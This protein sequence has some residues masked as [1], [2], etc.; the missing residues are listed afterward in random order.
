[1]EGAEDGAALLAQRVEAL[2]EREAAE[3]VDQAAATAANISEVTK[4]SAAPVA[5]WVT[6]VTT[7]P[8]RLVGT[9]A[10]AS[11]GAMTSARPRLR[12]TLTIVGTA[13][14]ENGGTT[15]S[16]ATMR[17]EARR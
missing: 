2:R 1:V 6:T 13:R 5:A 12:M 11:D 9:S 7:R 4:P 14:V 17:T 15:T 3:D 10:C 16:Q 8:G